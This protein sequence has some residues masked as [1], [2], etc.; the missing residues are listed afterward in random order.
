MP[1]IEKVQKSVVLSYR[2]SPGGLLATSSSRTART[3]L[4]TASL[5]ET[6]VK[7]GTNPHQ[8]GLHRFFEDDLG[9][10]CV[11]D[12][13]SIRTTFR[14][15]EMRPVGSSERRL[16]ILSSEISPSTVPKLYRIR[17][18]S[19]AAAVLAVTRLIC[20]GHARPGDAR[21]FIFAAIWK[22]A[23]KMCS[24]WHGSNFFFVPKILPWIIQC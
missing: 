16:R 14:N 8:A 6:D 11:L 23:G 21:V 5:C 9:P 22:L 18:I 19:S 10:Q 4:H 13:V 1:R 20:I 2:D 7:N 12:V 15:L 24:F 3:E 17:V